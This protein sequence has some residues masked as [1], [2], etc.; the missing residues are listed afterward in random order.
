[1][2]PDEIVAKIQELDPSDDYHNIDREA[3]G[4]V[5]ARG[6]YA[7]LDRCIRIVYGELSDWKDKGGR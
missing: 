2:T 3:G 7:A 5:D 4:P 6:Y 1:M